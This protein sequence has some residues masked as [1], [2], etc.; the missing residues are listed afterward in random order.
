MVLVM[1]DDERERLIRVEEDLKHV[2][3]TV[4]ETKGAVASMASDISALRLSF[5][6]DR[7]KRNGVLAALGVAWGVIVVAAANLRSWLPG[8]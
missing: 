6:E 7:A 5:R 4:D 8:N 1:T 3:K 2:S